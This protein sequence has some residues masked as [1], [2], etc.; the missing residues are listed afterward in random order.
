VAL[1]AALS[2]FFLVRMQV[3]ERWLAVGGAVLLIVPGLQP[4]LIGLAAVSPIVLRHLLAW[5]RLQPA[6]A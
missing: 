2:N 4:T 1:S 3:W 6:P 5:R